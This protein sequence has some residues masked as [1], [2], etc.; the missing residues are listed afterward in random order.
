MLKS[1][2]E[3]SEKGQ[4]AVIARAYVKP[5]VGNNFKTTEACL[6]LFSI[7]TREQAYKSIEVT[8]IS[9]EFLKIKGGLNVNPRHLDRMVCIRGRFLLV[10]QEDLDESVAR[11]RGSTCLKSKH[12]II[13]IDLSKRAGVGEVSCRLIEV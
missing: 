8:N 2:T 1:A 9:T 4:I 11:A 3:I 7:T 13:A 10:A 12:R 6:L 5:N